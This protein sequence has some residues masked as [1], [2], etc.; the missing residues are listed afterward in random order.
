M[1]WGADVFPTTRN[2]ARKAALADSVN[3]PSSP[4]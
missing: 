3:D 1:D 4:I 2:A